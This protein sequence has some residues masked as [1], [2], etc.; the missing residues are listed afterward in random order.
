MNTVLVS[1]VP[2]DSHTRV[3]NTLVNPF[4]L[5]ASD[6]YIWVSS[7]GGSAV[8]RYKI[9]DCDK[10][11]ITIPSPTSMTWGK[12]RNTIYVATTEGNIYTIDAKTMT[13]TLLTTADRA[14][15]G[16]TGIAYYD[17]KLYVVV[18]SLMYV[19]VYD[20]ETSP[21][22]ELTAIVDEGLADFMY[23]P[24]DVTASDNAIYITYA[25]NSNIQPGFGYINKYNPKTS[26]M[27]RFASRGRLAAPYTVVVE[28]GTVYVSNGSGYILQY[29]AE[30]EYTGK[31]RIDSGSFFADGLRSIAVVEEKVYYVAASS[32]G[33]MGTLGV[34]RL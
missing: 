34:I 7:T 6:K 12:C 31:L 24:L 11:S 30:G 9:H 8:V 14:S 1:T 25:M 10:Q 17:K 15:T 19:Q 18:P 29:T 23:R 5:L 16:I 32:D 20:V 2:G 3:D 33:S 28:R 21:P 27:K 22:K 13:E 26:K 4:G